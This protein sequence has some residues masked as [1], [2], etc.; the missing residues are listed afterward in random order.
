MRGAK[1]RG[2]RFVP[3]NV[4]YRDIIGKGDIVIDVGCADDADFSQHM[5]AAHG[6]TA[7]GI[8]PT[9]KHAAA[10][11]RLSAESEHFHYEPVAVAS[12]SGSLTFYESDENVS[13]S[14]LSD[15]VNVIHDSGNDYEVEA[16]DLRDL[17][18]RVGA[19]RIAILKLDLEGAEYEVL[20]E[21]S[22]V[23]LEPFE[24]IFV[25]FHHHAVSRY[26]Q[27]DTWRV[28]DRLK[29]LGFDSF[30]L[31]DHNFLFYR[32]P[33]EPCRRKPT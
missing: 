12:R 25:E 19:D 1:E 6:V 20:E 14:L 27:R 31:D 32:R 5:M 22:A 16:L 30:S 33:E 2:V 21:A 13:G 8:D 18:S 17:A 28:V 9:R 26:R 24:Q 7:W 4:I 23:T 10:L 15:H 29:A 3:P 11:S